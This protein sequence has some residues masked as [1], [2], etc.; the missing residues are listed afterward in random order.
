MR[1]YLHRNNV[2]HNSDGIS[3]NRMDEVLKAERKKGGTYALRACWSKKILIKIEDIRSILSAGKITNANMFEKIT[4]W[5]VIQLD[6]EIQ[7]NAQ[8]YSQ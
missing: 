4:D 3:K 2:I 7:A 5:T 8:S 6:K 1:R